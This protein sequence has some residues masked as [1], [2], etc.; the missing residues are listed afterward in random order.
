MVRFQE[1]GGWYGHD[2]L[3]RAVGMRLVWTHDVR[4]TDSLQMRGEAERGADLHR[5][6]TAAQRS[7]SAMF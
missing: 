7:S 2:F 5:R 3:D 4:A 1:V 6:Y